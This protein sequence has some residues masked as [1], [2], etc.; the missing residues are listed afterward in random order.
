MY[1]LVSLIA[2]VCVTGFILLV[3]STD[4]FILTVH[5]VCEYENWRYAR[6]GRGKKSRMLAVISWFRLF[7][8]SYYGT[9]AILFVGMRFPVH[10]MMSIR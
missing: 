4:I 3:K 9:C 5:N 2:S 10:K 6:P 7:N 8:G 1:Q